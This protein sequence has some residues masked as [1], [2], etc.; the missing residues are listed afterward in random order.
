MTAL[1]KVIAVGLITVFLAV[2]VRQ[3]KAEYALLISLCGGAVM[4]VICFK[5]FGGYVSTLKGLFADIS[6]GGEAL[7][8]ALKAV[9]IGYI[10]EFSAETAKDFGQSSLAA[11]IVL[12]GKTAIFILAMP[13][14]YKLITLSLSFVK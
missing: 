1:F 14:L 6:V 2:F 13:M 7:S 11:K 8:T 9:G 5:T 4:V 12:A 3:Y 10:T